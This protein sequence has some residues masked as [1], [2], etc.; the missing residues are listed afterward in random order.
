M[1]RRLWCRVFGH[2]DVRVMTLFL[3]D[4]TAYRC[5]YCGE[6]WLEEDKHGAD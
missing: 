1:M 2:V 5:A 4:K 3:K 6:A